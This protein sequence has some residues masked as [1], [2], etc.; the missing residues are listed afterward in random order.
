MAVL[1]EASGEERHGG[2]EPQSLL[3][4]TLQVSELLQVLGVYRPFRLT[5]GTTNAQTFALVPSICDLLQIYK[6]WWM[7]WKFKGQDAVS[8]VI[9]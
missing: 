3:D 2:E 4:H 5:F 8:Y 1:A 9:E 7:T 6:T